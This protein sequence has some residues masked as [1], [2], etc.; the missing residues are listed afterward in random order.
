[1]GVHARNGIGAGRLIVGP[2]IGEP[3]RPGLGVPAQAR[4]RKTTERCGLAVRQEEWAI[5]LDRKGS[6]ARRPG[7]AIRCEKHWRIS[8]TRAA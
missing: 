1:M 2:G 8:S 5:A 7:H 3:Q 4:V 6:A